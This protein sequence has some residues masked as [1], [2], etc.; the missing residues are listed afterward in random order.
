MGASDGGT[1]FAAKFDGAP[2]PDGREPRSPVPPEAELRFAHMDALG[3]PTPL[4]GE[5]LSDVVERA[6]E[7]KSEGVFP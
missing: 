1:A 2:D 3:S 6:V 4:V 7:Q 5:L